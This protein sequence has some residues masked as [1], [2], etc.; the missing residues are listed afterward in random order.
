MNRG[1][2]LTWLV[3]FTTS[4]QAEERPQIIN[5]TPLEIAAPG[6]NGV[7]DANLFRHYE[8]LKHFARGRQ[9]ELKERIPEALQA[10]QLANQFDG[11]SADLI[12]HML[13]LCFKMQQ[14]ATAL[15]LL[16]RSLTI[17]PQQPDLWMR[18]VQEL[19]D[20]DR[21]QEVVKMVEQTFKTI[22]FK[23]HPAFAADL[24]FVR[25]S[26]FDALKQY[27]QAAESY[28]E[29]LKLAQDRNRFLEDPFSPTLE[30]MPSE[31]AKLLERLARCSGWSGAGSSQRSGRTTACTTRCW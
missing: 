2:L 19:H 16:R 13:P 17:D 21:H 5:D 27:P 18:Y 8:G 9:L 31:E 12:R 11:Q 14:T 22:D 7:Q 3:L 20:L 29:A 10:Y 28:R 6:R 25:G 24:Y 15:K 1:L 4:V 26:S 23:E 30:E